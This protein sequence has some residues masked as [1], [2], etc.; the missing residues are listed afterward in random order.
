MWFVVAPRTDTKHTCLQT[1]LDLMFK[2]DNHS[3]LNIQHEFGDLYD[4]LKCTKWIALMLIKVRF[5]PRPGKF[6]L[7]PIA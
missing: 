2:Y 7:R 3:R 4:D 5:A 6:P 1:R